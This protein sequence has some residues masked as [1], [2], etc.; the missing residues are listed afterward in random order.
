[1]AE[2]GPIPGALAGSGL[3]LDKAV[4]N[5]VSMLGVGIPQA[6]RMA[7]LNPA[8][9]LGV[10]TTKGRVEQGFDADLLLLDRDLR[11]VQTIIAGK[12]CFTKENGA[13]R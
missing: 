13:Q 7:S 3:T 5:A 9:V 11:V 2:D 4:R 10:E 1:M 12:T 8:Q 6:I